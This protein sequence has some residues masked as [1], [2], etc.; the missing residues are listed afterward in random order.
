MVAAVVPGSQTALRFVSDPSFDAPLGTTPAANEY[1]VAV[2]TTTHTAHITGP[3]T[4]YTDIGFGTAATGFKCIICYKKAVGD[5]TTTG[6]WQGLTTNSDGLVASVILSGVDGTTPINGTSDDDTNAF[7]VTQTISTDSGSGAV[8]TA[9]GIAIAFFV[10]DLA[11]NYQTGVTLDNG[12]TLEVDFKG[13]K[14]AVAI[15]S[16]VYTGTAPL[17]STLTTTDTGDENYGAMALFTEAAA[18]GITGTGASTEGADTSAATGQVGHQGTAAPTEGA[19]TS[20][21]VGQL[22]H[23]GTATPTEGD[24]TSAASGQVGHQGTAAVTEA[25]DTSAAS[26]EVTSAGS[27]TG[28]SATTE[29]DDTSAASGQIGHQGTAAVTEGDDASAASGA[30]SASITGTAAPSEADD[31][32]AASGIVNKSITGTAAPTEGDDTSTAIGTVPT[33]EDEYAAA[34]FPSRDFYWPYWMGVAPRHEVERRARERTKAMRQAFGIIPP[35]AETNIA[36]VAKK[37]ASAPETPEPEQIA[38][39]EKAVDDAG[40]AWD[41]RYAG[42]M[43]A[44][45]EEFEEMNTARKAVIERKRKAGVREQ[46]RLKQEAARVIEIRERRRA[47]VLRRQKIQRITATA[48]LLSAA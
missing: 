3:P 34:G 47:V 25:D 27:I 38:T 24:D 12:F 10:G 37:F 5:E 2:G 42:H 23:Q 13:N 1:I 41:N 31:T 28:T 22:G 35:D 19:D 7:T 15:G 44:L 40:I 14:G 17:K 16:L 48:L 8:P 32:V 30:V 18:G 9:D 46:R 39:L 6:A 29:T 45:R 33:V 11:V 36:T 26:G 4:G 43:K 21:G 20:V